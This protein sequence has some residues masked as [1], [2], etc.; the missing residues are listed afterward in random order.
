MSERLSYG[1]PALHLRGPFSF[2]AGLSA[3]ASEG[4]AFPAGNLGDGP[5]KR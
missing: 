4:K 2:T 1:R 5:G 3:E